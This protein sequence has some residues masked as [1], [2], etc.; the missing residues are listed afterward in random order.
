MKELIHIH[1]KIEEN[2][3]NY[4]NYWLYKL[5]TLLQPI[6]KTLFRYHPER[7]KRIK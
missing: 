1:I 6:T 7:Q 4:S 3:F 2:G 5:I